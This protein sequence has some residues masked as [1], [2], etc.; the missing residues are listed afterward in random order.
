MEPVILVTHTPY[1][2]K[3]DY[4]I[5]SEYIYRVQKHSTKSSIGHMPV[6]GAVRIPEV[7]PLTPAQEPVNLSKILV[8]F[9]A[10]LAGGLMEHTSW[11][12]M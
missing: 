10:Y 6:T 7:Q 5:I 1:T 4:S 9:Y 3:Y 11:G 2:S 12:R 8:H